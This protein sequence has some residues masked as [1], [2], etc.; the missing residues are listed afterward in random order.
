MHCAILS[1][2]VLPD[3]SGR[4]I[5]SE[6]IR[7]VLDIADRWYGLVRI[8]LNVLVDNARAT[9]LYR[10]FG[11]EQEGVLRSWAI[12]EGRLAD[13]LMMARVQPAAAPAAPDN[14]P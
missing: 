7:Q 13:A 1:A 10:K 6:L 9:A 2:A 8:E 11:F 3:W 4:G 14:A 12:H 5:G